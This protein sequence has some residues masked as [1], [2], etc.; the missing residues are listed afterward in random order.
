MYLGQISEIFRNC[1]KKYTKLQMSVEA[2]K[3]KTR[4]TS[5]KFMTLKKKLHRSEIQAMSIIKPSRNLSIPSWPGPSLFSLEL[6]FIY[7][8]LRYKCATNIGT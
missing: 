6:N 1:S 2:Y 5:S 4:I 7:L 8:C 3:I